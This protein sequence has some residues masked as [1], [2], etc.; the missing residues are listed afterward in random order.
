MKRMH[1]NIIYYINTAVWWV[2]VGTSDDDDG[3]DVWGDRPR[4]TINLDNI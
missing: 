4:R 2:V 3:G 1:I